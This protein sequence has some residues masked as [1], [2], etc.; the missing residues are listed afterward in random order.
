MKTTEKEYISS[1]AGS[2]GCL[3]IIIAFGVLATVM[4]FIAA[5]YLI[6]F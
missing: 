6:F 1:Y 2:G 4:L 5:I 3:V